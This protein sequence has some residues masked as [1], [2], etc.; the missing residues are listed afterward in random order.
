VLG[1]RP[2][3]ARLLSADDDITP[4]GHPVIVLSHGYW[5]RKF[6]AHTALLNQ[7]IRVNGLSMTVVGVA[8]RNF[9]SVVSGQTPDIYAP[10]AMKAQLTPGNLDNLADRQAYWLNVFARLKTGVSGQQATAG[11]APL[12]RAILEQE[13]AG[14]G[15][16]SGRSLERFL[17]GKLEIRPAS[18]GVNELKSQW[19]NPLVAVMAM[20]GRCF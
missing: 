3:I 7:T 5:T 20:A 18:Q 17:A 1:V 4:G 16:W 8:P 14:R 12:F 15:H 9:R 6:A 13:A 2:V 10:I 11:M 19:E